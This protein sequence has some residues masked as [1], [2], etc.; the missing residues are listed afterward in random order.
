MSKNNRSEKSTAA[1]FLRIAGVLTLIC[2][3]VALMLAAV[4]AVTK[5]RIEENT[6]NEKLRAVSRIFGE[7]D[8]VIPVEG[9]DPEILLVVKDGAT[10]GYCVSVLPQGYGGEIDMLVGV[11]PDRSVK[12]VE[13]ISMSETPGVGSRVKSD[14]NFLPQFAGKSGPFEP[15]NGA[16]AISGAS[17]SSRAV[18]DGVNAAITADFDFIAAAQKAGLTVVT[19]SGEDDTTDGTESAVPDTT[20]AP[21]TTA[22]PETTAIPVVTDT[23]PETY[24]DPASVGGYGEGENYPADNMY[25]ETMD[26]T[27]LYQEHET[28]DTTTAETDENGEPVTANP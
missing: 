9:T 6:N 7:V 23:Q 24:I 11:C 16:D 27:G 12:G 1:Y 22:P 17:I 19:P 5:N 10:P 3:V 18:M 13:I 28:T 26:T 8:E 14:E 20:A 15:G 21:D 4:N 25:V 2:S